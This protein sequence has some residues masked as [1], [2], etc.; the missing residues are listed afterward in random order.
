MIIGIDASLACRKEPTG[1]E[2]YTF[3][4]ITHLSRVIPRDI[5]VRLY[6]DRDFPENFKKN[7]P[8]HWKLLV[9]SWPPRFL[10]TQIR[11][12]LELLLHRPDIFFTPG[13][14]EPMIHP[15][16]SVMMVHDVA[17]WRFPKAYSWFNRVY[18]LG[19]TLRAYKKNPVMIVP[20]IFTQSELEAFARERGVSRKA[21]I[22]V[23]PHGFTPSFSTFLSDD[24]G[25]LSRF[26][27]KPDT[28][29]I[30]CIG[31]VEYKKNIDTI[32]RSFEKLKSSSTEFEK[33][34]LVLAGKPGYGY[35]VIQKVLAES[36]YSADIIETGWISEIERQ[37][38]LK[39]ARALVFVSRYEGFGLPILE[40][41]SSGVPVITSKGLGLEEVG[42]VSSFYVS[43]ENVEDITRA[44][45]DVL[46]LSDIERAE[47]IRRST[48]HLTQFSWIDSA[49][50]TYEA[51][52]HAY[53]IAGTRTHMI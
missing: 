15:A 40:A 21:E 23:I 36:I 46:S 37:S 7:I 47:R 24:V 53:K 28:P 34:R 25:T 10:W 20:S 32:I 35:E 5:E 8:T 12:S 3:H 31:R 30:I 16:C 18:T 43:P 14:V 29:Y 44:I 38:L 45:H 48:L 33:L 42:G 51:L 17:A 4:I 13:H 27:L 50:Q 9:L 19:C 26:S 39:Y 1:V 52:M 11:L 41:L 22:V 2:A 49:E 6:S